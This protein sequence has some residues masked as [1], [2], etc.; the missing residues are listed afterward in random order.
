MKDVE[1]RAWLE[2]EISAEGF[3]SRAPKQ[4]ALA[5]VALAAMEVEPTADGDLEIALDALA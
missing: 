4:V 5:R 3:F 1:L 2:N